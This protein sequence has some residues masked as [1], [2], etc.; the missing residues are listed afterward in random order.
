MGTPLTANEPGAPC[1]VCWGPGK[2]FGTG[3]TP[4][5]I[6]V[7]LT[8]LLPANEW[9]PA[10]EQLLLTPHL[11]EQAPLPCNY[12]ILD[13]HFAWSFTWSPISTALQVKHVLT[14]TDAFLAS[15]ADLCGLALAN[16]NIQPVFNF[17][18]FGSAEITWSLG[19]L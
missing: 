6:T 17:A 13:G 4:A 15:P 19:G 7:T 9:I 18:M 5:V 8:A 1:L 12:G 3:A 10:L 11:L 16:E 14:D 2:P